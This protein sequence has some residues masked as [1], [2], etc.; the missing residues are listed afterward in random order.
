MDLAHQAIVKTFTRKR[1]W[2]PASGSLL[3]HLCGVM[4][5]DLSHRGTSY[6]ALHS[7]TLDE[8][9]VQMKD[10]LPT[11]EEVTVQRS[12]EHHLLEFIGRRNP[13]A[14]SLAEYALFAG[15]KTSREFSDQ[16]RISVAKVEHLRKSLRTLISDYKCLHPASDSPAARGLT[17][18]SGG[19]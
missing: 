6:E 5:S 3:T 14:R 8:T 15:L 10:Y 16:M 18:V 9:V 4:K 2:D 12:E 1:P 17:K 13:A 7:Q 11:P 19:K